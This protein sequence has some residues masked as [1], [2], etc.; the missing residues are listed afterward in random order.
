[1]TTAPTNAAL[2]AG[3]Q[4]FQDEGGGA[5]VLDIIQRSDVP[6]LMSDVLAG[7][8]KAG[9]LLRQLSIVLDGINSAPRRRPMLC[10]VCPRAL[11]RNS[12]F[13]VVVATPAC[14][15][16]SAGLSLAICAKCA[17]DQAAIT[18]KAAVALRRIWPDLRPVTI[19]N[20]AGGRA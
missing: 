5:L 18:D 8:Y 19:T 9:L 14:D 2:A 4:L 11:R 6:S 16:P 12:A 10:G 1:M 7:N 13:A 15:K 17:S 3:V 20:P